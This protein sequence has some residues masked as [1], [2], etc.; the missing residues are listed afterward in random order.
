MDNSFMEENSLDEENV[1]KTLLDLLEM[2]GLYTTFQ[3]LNGAKNI[4][5]YWEKYL[6]DRKKEEEKLVVSDEEKIE[7]NL[8][9][10]IE[11]AFNAVHTEK[12]DEDSEDYMEDMAN[13]MENIL[14]TAFN[15]DQFIAG[16]SEF[17]DDLQYVPDDEKL[18]CNFL[19]TM[20]VM[21]R[22]IPGYYPKSDESPEK[23][24][25]KKWLP[26][27]KKMAT[28]ISKL[29][30]EDYKILYS[31]VSDRRGFFS[32]PAF[33]PE[34]AQKIAYMSDEDYASFLIYTQDGL[35]GNNPII[36]LAKKQKLLMCNNEFINNMYKDYVEYGSFYS[37]E[38][39]QALSDIEKFKRIMSL[40]YL[41]VHKYMPYTSYT[42]EEIESGF[43][44]KQES[45]KEKQLIQSPEFKEYIQILENLT[46]EQFAFIAFDNLSSSTLM[47]MYGDEQEII[48][49]RL[50][51]LSLVD[52]IAISKHN[53]NASNEMLITAIR[54]SQNSVEIND[55]ALE[56]ANSTNNVYTAIDRFRLPVTHESFRVPVASNFYQLKHTSEL[57]D[58]FERTVEMFQL[59]S[60]VIKEY[61]RLSEL[62]DIDFV[63]EANKYNREFSK[64][65]IYEPPKNRDWSEPDSIEEKIGEAKNGITAYYT[66]RI[67][68]LPKELKIKL[69]NMPNGIV[70]DAIQVTKNH[71]AVQLLKDFLAKKKKRESDAASLD[72]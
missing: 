12:V 17:F 8:I 61:R 62:S 50:N 20:I 4:K 51:G 15:S 65:D 37:L 40:K 64:S 38:E 26:V 1:T 23:S 53:A 11:K 56:M 10:A 28:G 44:D 2:Y 58:S 55:M 19:A 39:F 69:D 18:R 67:L 57:M 66:I 13:N 36:R 35:D 68:S 29:S 72:D 22:M 45:E 24:V 3:M 16:V 32:E 63:K 47:R 43:A 31:S 42:P 27:K 14:Q 52:L 9:Q 48:Q 33:L 5:Q 54:N 21:Q 70:F 60:E 59:D 30:Q 46:D 71:Q 25:A 7:N 41:A 6:D 34:H 49:K